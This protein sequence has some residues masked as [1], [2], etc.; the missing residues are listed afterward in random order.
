MIYKYTGHGIQTLGSRRVK[1]DHPTQYNDPFEFLPR[2]A[3]SVTDAQIDQ[4][5]SDPLTQQNFYGIWSLSNPG[6][7]HDFL[8]WLQQNTGAA[9]QAYRSAF[10]PE[11]FRE[12]A[13]RYYA[14]CCFSARRDSVLMWSHY[15]HSHAGMAIGFDERLLA[16]PSCFFP[17]S[18]DH[19]RQEYHPVMN[20]GTTNPVIPVLTRKAVDW[21]YEDEIRMLVA[22]SV[23]LREGEHWFFPFDADD[24]KEVFL[25]C[26]FPAESIATVCS[27]VANLYPHAHVRRMRPHSSTYDL[28][29]EPLP[30]P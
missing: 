7:F 24:V 30:C 22:W 5:L 17:V 12:I 13:G 20:M 14:V 2:I 8:Q 28:V 18:Y 1:V 27:I 15:A 26:A 23:C 9:R 11:R 16:P 4:K 10:S 19:Q 25:G 29:E 3:P 6:S 21:S